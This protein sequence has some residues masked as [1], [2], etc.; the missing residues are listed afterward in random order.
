VV[1][2]DVPVLGLL[3]LPRDNSLLVPEQ[4]IEETVDRVNT[5]SPRS[6]EKC[7]N[8]TTGSRLEIGASTRQDAFFCQALFLVSEDP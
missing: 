4:V 6:P 2:I 5:H 1:S 3:T 8:L 7:P